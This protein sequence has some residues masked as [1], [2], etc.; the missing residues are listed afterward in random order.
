MQGFDR[1]RG[2]SVLFKLEAGRPA[3]MNW[4]AAA[5]EALERSEGGGGGGV[6][7]RMVEAAKERFLDDSVVAK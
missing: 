2:G 1:G 6:R 4:V 7:R 3:L 5:V